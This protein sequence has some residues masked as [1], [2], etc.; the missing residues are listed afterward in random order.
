MFSSF[1]SLW[2]HPAAG[3]FTIKENIPKLKELLNNIAV[4]EL[5]NQDLHKSINPDILCFNNINHDF[6]RQLKLIGPF[7]LMN[8]APIFWTKM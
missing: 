4:R 7:G 3:G 5:K 2:R 6:Y 8:K 1:N